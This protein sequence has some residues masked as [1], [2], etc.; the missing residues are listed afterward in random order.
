M[1]TPPLSRNNSNSDLDLNNQTDQNQ[2]SGSST[3]SPSAESE[4]GSGKTWKA[5]Q[6]GG[7]A[8]KRPTLGSKKSQPNLF[9]N[10]DSTR[11]NSSHT[12]PVTRDAKAANST[13]TKLTISNSTSF[14]P[15]SKAD[16]PSSPKS[17]NSSS[18]A[19][20]TIVSPKASEKGGVHV[21]DLPKALSMII[22]LGI[23]NHIL[24]PEKLALLLVTVDNQYGKKRGD[25]IIKTMLREPLFII[26]YRSAAGTLYEKLNIIERYC[27]PFISHHL[28]HQKLDEL[29]QKVMREYDKVGDEVTKLSEGLRAVEQVNHPKIVTLMAPLMKLV[30]DYFFGSDMKLKSS[31]FPDPIKKLLIEIDRQVIAQFEKNGSGEVRELLQRRKSALVGFISTFSFMTIWAPKLAADT[32]KSPGFYAKLSSYINSYLVNKL[33]RFVI[34]ILINQEHQSEKVKKHV[35]DYAKELKLTAQSARQLQLA[36]AEKGGMLSSIK[37]L[38]SLRSSSISNSSAASKETL[39]EDS[40]FNE[41]AARQ[42]EMQRNR[43]KKLTKFVATAGFDKISLEFFV[44]IRNKI[45]D[46]KAKDYNSFTKDPVAYCHQQLEVFKMQKGE[47]NTDPELFEKIEQSINSYYGNL[48]RKNEEKRLWLNS[49]EM[50]LEDEKVDEKV[51]LRNHLHRWAK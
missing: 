46:L 40:G 2:T 45:I 3:N 21:S 47:K 32:K 11:P 49:P 6:G 10:M 23:Q 20:Q 27:E 42:S 35:D 30:G 14:M 43:I 18:S 29:L 36:G 31:K 16:V 28:D 17:P 37:G 39:D 51:M 41:E 38:L 33:D 5:A 50:T 44:L 24:K 1:S 4:K 7:D 19:T 12:P 13:P 22:D 15:I 9:K 48:E 8:T 34:D 26:D 25:A